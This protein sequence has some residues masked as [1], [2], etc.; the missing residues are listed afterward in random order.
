LKD[1]ASLTHISYLQY[2]LKLW[3]GAYQTG[4]T[5]SYCAWFTRK[6]RY[7]S[8]NAACSQRT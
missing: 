4:T 5:T 2:N 3:S 7:D 6:N 1:I 8:P